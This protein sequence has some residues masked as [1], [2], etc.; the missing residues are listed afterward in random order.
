MNAAE[1]RELWA[2]SSRTPLVRADPASLAASPL[3]EDAKH[4]LAEA[5]LPES[6]FFG[7]RCARL[8]RGVTTLTTLVED[9]ARERRS[10]FHVLGEWGGGD[11]AAAGPHMF[12]CVDP[13]G[14]GQVVAV[15]PGSG[16]LQF[17][18]SGVCEFGQTLLLFESFPTPGEA[19]KSPRRVLDAL[20]ALRAKLAEIDPETL[21][22]HEE[23]ETVP[24]FWPT[25][26]DE[27]EFPTSLMAADMASE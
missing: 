12:A 11:E 26:I 24:S 3:G 15:Q 21:R 5:G 10:T 2:R 17:V 4:F 14:G 9:E 1:F 20:A 8:A 16:I 25:L 22:Q 13:A 23:N 19:R 6:G 18:N 27:V 7:L